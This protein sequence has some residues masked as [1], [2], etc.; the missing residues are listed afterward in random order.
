MTLFEEFF[1]LRFGQHIFQR[2]NI[3]EAYMRLVLV[4]PACTKCTL[5][6]FRTAD[7]K[8]ED[9]PLNKLLWVCYIVIALPLKIFVA[10]LEEIC[11]L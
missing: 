8:N 1:F 7:S 6:L 2:V 11:V 4:T 3:T 10:I 9:F 5:Y